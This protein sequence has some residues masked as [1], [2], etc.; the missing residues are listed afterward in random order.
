MNI[1]CYPVKIEAIDADTKDLLFSV[2]TFDEICCTLDMKTLLSPDNI[3]A[4]LQAIRS[5]VDDLKLEKNCM[6][7]K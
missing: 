5:A 3:D 6:M 2:T 7:V 1:E 4:I